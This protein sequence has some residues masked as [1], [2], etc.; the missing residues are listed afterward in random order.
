MLRELQLTTNSIDFWG[1][2]IT[3]RSADINTPPELLASLK[4]MLASKGVEVSTMIEDVE[5][6]VLR[7]SAE[8]SLM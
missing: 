4:E 1:Q 8:Q 7:F 5:K 2:P 3:G 6:Y